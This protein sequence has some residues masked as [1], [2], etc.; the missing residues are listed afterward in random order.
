M[1]QHILHQ[2]ATQSALQI[3]QVKAQ[4]THDENNKNKQSKAHKIKQIN[5]YIWFSVFLW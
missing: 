4:E 5:K 1:Q 3:R 2:K